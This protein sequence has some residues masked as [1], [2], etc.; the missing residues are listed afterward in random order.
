MI[1]VAIVDDEPLAQEI[2]QSYLQKLPDTELVGVC[3]NAL[4]A[5]ALLNKQ[6]VD[7]LLLDI[8]LPEITGIE[9][10]K[11][12]KHPPKVIFTTAYTEHALESYELNAIDYLV[13]PIAFDRFL[14]AINKVQS[15]LQPAHAPTT[16]LP[17]D[18][19]LFVRSEGKWIKIDLRKLWFVEGLKDY[20]RLWTDDGRIT[21]HSTMKNFEEQLKPYSNFVRVHKSHIINL[22]YIAEVD[23]NSIQIKDQ[24][25]AIGSTYKDEVQKILDSYKLL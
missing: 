24:F 14:R 19:L 12:L 11:S 20:V 1:R 21:V 8:N 22:E 9:F 7:L 16:T 17:S 6:T 10:L 13:K 2:L 4:E 5:F 23:G 18:K 3:K 15:E 25:I